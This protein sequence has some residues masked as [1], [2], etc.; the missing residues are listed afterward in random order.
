MYGMMIS[1]L[2]RSPMYDVMEM[3][4]DFQAVNMRFLHP[5]ITVTVMVLLQYFAKRV[6]NIANIGIAKIV[7]LIEKLITHIKILEIFQLYT[8]FLC[9]IIPLQ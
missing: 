7:V 5:V 9:M 1:I 6:R 8:K 4:Q 2:I 3:K